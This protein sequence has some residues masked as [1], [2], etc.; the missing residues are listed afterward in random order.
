MANPDRILAYLQ[1][2]RGWYSDEDLSVALG[3]RPRQQVNQICRRLAAEGRIRR[4][5]MGGVIGNAAIGTS[6]RGTSETGSLPGSPSTTAAS[7]ESLAREVCSEHYGRRLRPGRVPGVPKLFDLVSEDGS[8]VGD[9]KYYDLVRGVAD[10]PAKFSVIAEHVWLLEKI[11]P[12]VRFLVF[13]NN[14]A[15]PE[16]WLAKYGG[17]VKGIDFLFLKGSGQLSQ[18]A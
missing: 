18:I 17:L 1:E 15:V 11:E 5:D 12:R 8:V 6:S 2:T 14:P 16:R 10:P 3:I 9:A 13:G 7:F 4:G